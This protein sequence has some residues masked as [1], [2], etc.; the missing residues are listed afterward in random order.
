M[1]HYSFHLPDGVTTGP[2]AFPDTDAVWGETVR[3]SGELLRDLHG[4]FKPDSNWQVRVTD[5]SGRPVV[6]LRVLATRHA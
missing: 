5:G 6:T 2:I 1:P 4:R 3:L